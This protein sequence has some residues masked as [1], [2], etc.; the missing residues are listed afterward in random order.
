MLRPSPNPVQ[1]LRRG[2]ANLTSRV[3]HRYSADMGPLVVAGLVAFAVGLIRLGSR[4]Q[5]RSFD[6]DEGLRR[7]AEFGF[8]PFGRQPTEPVDAENVRVGRPF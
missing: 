1:I 2:I 8:L 7:G 3:G 5:P 6:R 4:I